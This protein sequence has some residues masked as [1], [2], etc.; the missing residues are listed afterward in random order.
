MFGITAKADAGVVI[1]VA[2]WKAL[3]SVLLTAGLRVAAGRAVTAVKR[4]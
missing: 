4:P 3:S 1:A 2:K